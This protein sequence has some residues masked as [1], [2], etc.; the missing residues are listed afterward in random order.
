MKVETVLHEN[1]LSS[2]HEVYDEI[3]KKIFKNLLTGGKA[4]DIIKPR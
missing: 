2:T 3:T 4:C 1:S